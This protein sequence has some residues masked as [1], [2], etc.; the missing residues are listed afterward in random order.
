M[1]DFVYKTVL[2]KLKQRILN[3]EFENMRLPDERS[4][5]QEYKV[6]RSS[7]KRA[8]EILASQGIVFK[9]RGSGTFINP[10]F[11][12][13]K[14]MFHYDGSNLGLTDSLVT[15]GQAQSVKVLNFAVVKAGKSVAE[16]LF[17]SP[18]DF[19]YRFER[20]RLVDD[21]PILVET[22][23]LPIKV[24]PEM[25][26]QVL[27]DSLFKYLE[28]VEGKSVN[29]SFLNLTVSPSTERDRQLLNLTE[30]EPVGVI[31]GIFFQDDGMPCEISEM[32]VHYKYMYF[33]TFVNLS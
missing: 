3:N 27:E 7:M 9:K 19:V 5:A 17:I 32:R 12:K 13:E 28:E 16:D 23:Y 26:E 15:L 4:L 20:L 21:K 31:S 10:L 30:N 22:S 33:N 25:T 8:L 1:T 6:S 24:A 18:E 29:K 2:K 11:S 14:S